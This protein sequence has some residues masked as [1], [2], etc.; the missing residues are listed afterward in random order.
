M[1][2]LDNKVAIITGGAMGMGY[3]C[4]KVMAEHGAKLALVDYSD[5]VFKTAEDL[6]KSG[7]QV[8]AFNADVRETATLKEVCKKVAED[9]GKI[10]ILINAAGIGIIKDFVETE[11]ELRDRIIDINFK[12][13]WNACKAAIPYMIAAKYG[14]I[15][16]FCS[17]SGILV[18]DPGM[19]AYAA[20]KG[21]IL[22]FT[23]ALA[24]E[25]ALN[26]ITVNAILPGTVDTPM[27][28]K[29]AREMCPENPQSVKDLMADAMP[30]KRFGKIEEA[31]QIAAFLAS[32]E[33]S[34][35]SG[36]SIVFDGCS[37]LPEN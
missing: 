27:V 30:M 3:G 34:Y 24:L 25:N 15:V 12:G 7:Y 2:K 22:G 16:N 9:Y 5:M 29:V 33:S 37:T 23:K 6:T 11:D 8:L 18:C 14:K 17:V 32:D 20:S 13:T 19:T 4:A 28:D 36:T 21:A 31:G 26:S 1:G 10:D 35:V